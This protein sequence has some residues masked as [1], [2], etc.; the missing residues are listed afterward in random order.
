MQFELL[1]MSTCA[2]NMYRREIK[3]TVKQILYIMLVKYWDKYTEMHSQEN[4]KIILM[5]YSFFWAISSYLPAYED[6]KER[7]FRNLDIQNSDAGELLKRQA[8]NIQKKAKVWNQEKILV[9]TGTM[10]RLIF[11]QIKTLYSR[12]INT[13]NT[14]NNSVSNQMDNTHKILNFI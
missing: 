11:T 8:H 6:G 7:V 10:T 2:R 9:S 4:V 13:I 1:M 3:L 14:S 12:R 5:F